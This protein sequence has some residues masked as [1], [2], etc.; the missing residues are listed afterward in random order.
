MAAAAAQCTQ[1]IAIAEADVTSA[2]AATATHTTTELSRSLKQ[3]KVPFAFEITTQGDAILRPQGPHTAASVELA[4]RISALSNA[5]KTAQY[6]EQLCNTWA[7]SVGVQLK[8]DA[9]A[10]DLEL[11][12]ANTP[13]VLAA[14]WRSDA[15]AASATGLLASLGTV[16]KG[17][18][19]KAVDELSRALA[20]ALPERATAS[21]RDVDAFW[22]F[23]ASKAA[24]LKDIP[25]AAKLAEKR[26]T[27]PVLDLD[28]T[29]VTKAKKLRDDPNAVKEAVHGLFR[30]DNNATMRGSVVLF[31]GESPV[32]QGLSA[33]NA[34]THNDFKTALRFSHRMVAPE[35]EVGKALAAAMNASNKR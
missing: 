14:V 31:P 35:S 32:R 33:A 21:K 8:R 19:P 3:K 11:E 22:A 10:A 7:V 28:P 24:D 20:K 12:R 17:G 15:L 30:Q 4:S 16:T 9:A 34:L 23:A 13:A 6:A 18:D 1:A 27:A 2:L 26:A 25:P 29:D 5:F